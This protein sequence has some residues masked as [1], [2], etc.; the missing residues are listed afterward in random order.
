MTFNPTQAD[1]AVQPTEPGLYLDRLGNVWRLHTD[2]VFAMSG[3]IREGAAS[4]APFQRLGVVAAAGAA[5]QK[6]TETKTSQDFVF[7][8]VQVDE[9]KLADIAYFA[10]RDVGEGRTASE[11]LSRKIA[12]AQARE[13]RGGAQ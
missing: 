3:R 9:A 1:L 13:L 2:G 11:K 6:P 5:P 10:L 12:R 4:Y 7:T 8:S